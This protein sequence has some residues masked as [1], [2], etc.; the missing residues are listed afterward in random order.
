MSRAVVLA[1][2]AR[3]LRIRGLRIALKPTVGD[4]KTRDRQ[5]ISWV[6]EFACTFHQTRTQSLFG[7]CWV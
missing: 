6:G 4:R 7:G 2:R 1:G 3:F 5:A